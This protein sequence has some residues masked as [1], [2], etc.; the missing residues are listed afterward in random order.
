MLT[1]R[2]LFQVVFEMKKR[3]VEKMN[4][5]KKKKEE[6]GDKDTEEE[7]KSESTSA[8]TEGAYDVRYVWMSGLWIHVCVM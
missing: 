1:L 5:E 3:E 7:S 2:D 8:A 4:E 6:E